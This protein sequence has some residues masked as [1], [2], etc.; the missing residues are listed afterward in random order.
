MNLAKDLNLG[1]KR[2]SKIKHMMKFKSRTFFFIFVLFN[3]FEKR[4]RTFGEYSTKASFYHTCF[5]ARSLRLKLLFSCYE[6]EFACH[7][8]HIHPIHDKLCSNFSVI[9]T[10]NL[11]S[12]LLKEFEQGL[13]WTCDRSNLFQR[14]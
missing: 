8:E 5:Q 4:D 11:M 13:K 6:N 2:L 9:L 12:G 3:L 7:F 10:K 1:G 14:P